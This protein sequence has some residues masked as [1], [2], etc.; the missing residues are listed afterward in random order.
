MLFV[1]EPHR[2]KRGLL[3]S[4]RPWV[5]NHHV[6]VC[7]LFVHGWTRWASRPRRVRCDRGTQNRGVF[8]STLAKNGV[9]IRLAGLEAPDS[10][11]E[12]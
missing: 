2:I 3:E 5:L 7:E 9:M 4:P 8:S 10:N 11:R 6:C 1:C 12:S